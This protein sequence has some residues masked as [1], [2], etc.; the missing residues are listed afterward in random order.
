[1]GIPPGLGIPP[2]Y[3]GMGGIKG[4]IARPRGQ[5]ASRLQ[6]GILHIYSGRPPHTSFP[7]IGLIVVSLVVGGILQISYCDHCE[8]SVTPT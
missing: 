2:V 1:M 4:R 6:R 8:L 5:S 7:K 3:Q